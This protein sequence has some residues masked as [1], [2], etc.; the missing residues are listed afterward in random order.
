MTSSMASL[1]E[2][3]PYI[4]R[5]KAV[6]YTNFP[7]LLQFICVISLARTVVVLVAHET[8]TDPLLLDAETFSLDIVHSGGKR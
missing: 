4:G 5:C 7:C 6:V 8:S 1:N 3:R 2:L